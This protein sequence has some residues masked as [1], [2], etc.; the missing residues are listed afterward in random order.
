MK[1]MQNFMVDLETLGTS[2]DSIILSIGIVQFDLS[3]GEI[4]ATFYRTIDEKSSRGYGLTSDKATEEWW[5]KQDA[6][7]RAQLR[8]GV[9]PLKSVLT[10]VTEFLKLNCK[11]SKLLWGNSAR[12][13]LGLLEDAYRAVGMET[14]WAFWNERCC[15][16]IV[17]L[18]PNIKDSMPKPEG[19][20]HPIVDC[21]Y[22]IEYVVRTIQSLK[23]A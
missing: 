10:E 19:A 1:Q 5:S 2:H 4:G 12:F 9:Q 6:K 23:N 3:T 22:Q 7:V 8:I 17:A 14:P 18:N 20:H 16:T 11:A 15:R 13:D 21:K